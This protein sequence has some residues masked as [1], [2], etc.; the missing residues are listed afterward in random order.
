MPVSEL[1]NYPSG[2]SKMKKA[3]IGQELGGEN[4]LYAWEEMAWQLY[5]CFTTFTKNKFQLD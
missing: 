3:W 2:I 4:Q 1:M 5:P